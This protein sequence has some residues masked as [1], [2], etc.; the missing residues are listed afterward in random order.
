MLCPIKQQ[1]QATH[2]TFFQPLL[3]RN[4]QSSMVFLCRLR[5]IH[6]GHWAAFCGLLSRAGGW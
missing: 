1:H 6:L 4:A 3:F 2:C 5:E